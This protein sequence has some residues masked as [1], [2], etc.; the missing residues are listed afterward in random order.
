MQVHRDDDDM[1]TSMAG[2]KPARSSDVSN[3][4]DKDR[5]IRG[6]EDEDFFRCICV[7]FERS[8]WGIQY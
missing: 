4:G 7:E 2:D 8:G 6:S 3:H 1:M 5:N